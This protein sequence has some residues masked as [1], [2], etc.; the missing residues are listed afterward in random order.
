MLL[1]RRPIG[2]PVMEDFEWNE[3]VIKVDGNDGWMVILEN[4]YVSIDPAMRGWMDGAKNS[5]LP[6]VKLGA[7]MRA[8]TIS[9]VIHTRNEKSFPLNS[10]VLVDDGGVQ[11]HC[12]LRTALDQ[13]MAHLLP[14]HNTN[15]PPPQA[16]LS[17]LGITGLTAYFGMMEKG[18]P[19]AGETVLISGAAGATGSVAAQLAKI[20]G[21]TVIGTAGS[22]EKCQW[23]LDNHICDQVVNYKKCQSGG[24]PKQIRLACKSCGSP[25]GV[26]IV[27]DN[28]GGQFLEA[29]LANLNHGA[30]I[31][32]CGAISQYNTA[33]LTSTTTKNG[34]ISKQPP[35]TGPRNYM[36]LLIK[37]ATMS[38]FVV[39]DYRKQYVEAIQNLASWI[40]SKQLIHKE[41]MF[42]GIHSFYPAFSSLF[43]GTNHGKVILNL[44]S[45]SIFQSRL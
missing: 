14:N 32:L 31:V 28:V 19:R 23:L 15:M 12:V 13:K 43:N 34:K 9:R 44:K 16:Y 39:F 1:V 10:L 45:S 30:R 3:E 17:V 5:Y 41:H 37:R 42:D 40:Q 21:C 35:I 8:S 11:T 20:H 24:M 7:V 36:T 22:D 18:K 6:P 33:G 26:D 4:M 27:F 29:A 25:K 38:G 2:K